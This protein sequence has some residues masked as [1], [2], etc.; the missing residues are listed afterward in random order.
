MIIAVILAQTF[1]AVLALISCAKKKAPRLDSVSTP[2]AKGTPCN[3]APEKKQEKGAEVPKEP[4][5]TK[6]AKAA[7]P[8]KEAEVKGKSEEDAIKS[9]D[10]L[11]S[12]SRKSERKAGGGKM[13]SQSSGTEL[14][15]IE[16][17]VKG[18]EKSRRANANKSKKEQV[19]KA[20]L[21]E[22]VPQG[23]DNDKRIQKDGGVTVDKNG[24]PISKFAA[25]K[26]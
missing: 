13:E 6:M 23:G 7:E 14:I 22:E 16:S 19:P 4:A 5:A 1:V 10:D 24:C 3:E 20:V 11:K 2:A 15:S 26:Y 18:G 17:N 25:P 12:K 8:S 9:T 21:S